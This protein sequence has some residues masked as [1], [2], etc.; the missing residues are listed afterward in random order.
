MAHSLDFIVR[1]IS[2]IDDQEIHF[3]FIGNGAMKKE[4]VSLAR[5]LRIPLKTS[6]FDPVLK[7]E[8]PRYLSVCDVSL[9]PLKNSDTFKTVIPSKIFEASAMEKPTLLGVEGQ[10]QEIIERYNAGLCFEP[11]NEVDFIE[12][13]TRMKN[14][15]KLYAELQHGCR[16]LVSDYD[17]RKLA[18]KML[19]IIAGTLT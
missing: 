17:R 11:E 1:S 2:N 16:R 19:D 6:P 3:L 9:A 14:D 18:K 15:R 7:E 8:V 12:K 13:A 10:A 5:G 4:V